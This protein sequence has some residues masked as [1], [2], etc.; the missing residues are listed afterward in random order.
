MYRDVSRRIKSDARA[1][2]SK[3]VK[4]KSVIT[5][6]SIALIAGVAIYLGRVYLKPA[7]ERAE[8][9]EAVLSGAYDA[10]VEVCSML[11]D[12]E[13]PEGVEA[14]EIGSTER[15]VQLIVLF[16]EVNIIKGAKYE[17]QLD[18]I[19]GGE[20]DPIDPV[21]ADIEVEEDGVVLTLT[22]KTDEDFEHGRL[23][24]DGNVIVEKAALE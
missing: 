13:L 14:P 5:I 17:Y 16:P 15:Y 19:N 24:H 18:R 10:R 12:H 23:V 1:A 22:Y 3:D 7:K 4:Q 8:A 9:K 11:E 6:I 21:H 2:D 20:G